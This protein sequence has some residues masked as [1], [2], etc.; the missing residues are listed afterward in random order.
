M[1]QQ[2]MFE[3]TGNT[4]TATVKSRTPPHLEDVKYDTNL[5]EIDHYIQNMWEV[6]AK[7]D[8]EIIVTPLYQLKVWFKRKVAVKTVIPP[9]AP[10]NVTVRKGRKTARPKTK[11]KTAFL[12][13]DVHIGF[14]REN[15]KLIPFHDRKAVGC[16]LELI[17]DV[18]PDRVVILGDLL[19][20]ADWSDKFVRDPN[21]MNL[22]Q[23]ALNE[24]ARLLGTIRALCPDAEMDYLEGNHSERMT[25]LV[26]AQLPAAYGLKPV[27]C[28]L[29]ALS[30]PVLLGLDKL[31]VTYHGDYPNNRVWLNRNLCCVH[32]DVV[33]PPG[34]TAAHILKN[35]NHSVCFGHV[36]RHE[37]ATEARHHHDGI[38]FY[39]AYSPGCLC[40]LDGVVPGTKRE[41]N[42]TQ[43][44]GVVHYE[45]G[46]K[47][48]TIRHIPIFNGRAILN[49]RYVSGRPF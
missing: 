39:A 41:Q 18:Q 28:E 14:R 19:D 5:W 4:A 3:V 26:K 45:D 31:G 7:V 32:G 34:Q 43:G 48:F 15:G 12:L 37:H 11:L 24:A 38:R 10:V 36:H 9:I 47:P 23:E 46:N 16:A 2:E 33:K 30:I 22:T 40:R 25:R 44:V 21:E 6:G 35:S 17:R 49:G 29:P 42:W 13:P 1:A 8:D 20:C 27:D